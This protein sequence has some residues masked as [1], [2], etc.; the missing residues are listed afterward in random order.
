MQWVLEKCQEWNKVS[1]DKV[2]LDKS[3]VILWLVGLRNVFG[4]YSE[5]NVNPWEDF[6][7]RLHDLISILEE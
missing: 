4:F 6:E 5:Y 7:Q 2:S 1:L 3:W